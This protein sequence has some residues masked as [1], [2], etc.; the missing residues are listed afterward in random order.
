MN[1]A[2][3]ILLIVGFILLLVQFLRW[4]RELDRQAKQKVREEFREIL[5][6]HGIDPKKVFND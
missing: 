6:Q 4:V 2:G 5:I 1:L 3:K